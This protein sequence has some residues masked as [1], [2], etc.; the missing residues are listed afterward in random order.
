MKEVLRISV[1]SSR[2]VFPARSLIFFCSTS[3]GGSGECLKTYNKI[4]VTSSSAMPP[5]TARVQF[6]RR[7]ETTVVAPAA[8]NTDLEVNVNSRCLVGGDMLRLRAFS[9]K[10]QLIKG[11]MGNASKGEKTGNTGWNRS[12]IIKR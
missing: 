10:A 4:P 6:P 9:L 7:M 2:V 8:D 11:S 1:T 5:L 12:G 3:T